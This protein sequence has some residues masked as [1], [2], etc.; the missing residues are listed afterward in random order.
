MILSDSAVLCD[1]YTNLISFNNVI[2]LY[3]GLKKNIK[4]Y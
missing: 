1:S 3:F 2:K 4:S